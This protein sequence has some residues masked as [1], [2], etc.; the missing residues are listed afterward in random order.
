MPDDTQLVD[1]VLAVLQAADGPLARRDVHA[2]VAKLQPGVRPTAVTAALVELGQ[3]GRAIVAGEGW[4]LTTGPATPPAPR[5]KT[6][7]GT[8]LIV[9]TDGACSGNPGPGGWAWALHDLSREA[10]GGEAHT[11]NQQMEIKAAL[12]AVRTLRHD[13]NDPILIRSDSRY[14]VDCFHKAWWRGWQRNGWT[15][16]QRKP[17]AN[18]ALW[19]PLVALVTA[20]GVTFEWVKAHNGDQMNEHVDQLAV[21]QAQAYRRR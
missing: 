18:R 10:S 13:T 9:Y 15:N 14:V 2:A 3:Q 20:G 19:E 21:A 12:E 8:T 17:V 4:T 11:T 1:A 16:A 6:S 5:A 7:T